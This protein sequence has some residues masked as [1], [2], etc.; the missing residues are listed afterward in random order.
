MAFYRQWQK[1]LSQSLV[2]LVVAVLG[3]ALLGLSGLWMVEQE[4][5]ARAGESLAL[6][7]T[8]VAGKLDAMLRERNGDIEI[9]AAAPQVRSSDA[10]QI[11]E[12]L[13]VVQRAYP[14]YTRLAVTDRTGRV[15]ASTDQAL[16]GQD[17]RD[18]SWF[19]AVWHVPRIYAESVKKT[20]QVMGQGHL[21]SVVISAPILGTHSTFHGAIMTEIDAA[22]WNRLVEDAVKPFAAQ[23]KSFGI[24]RYR[25]LDADGNVLLTQEGRDNP[26]INFRKVGLP[27]AVSVAAGLPG[28]VEEE[29]L[30][31]RVPVVTGYA[32]VQ[33]VHSL[34]TLQ[35]GVLVRAD[36][37]DILEN[38]Q[39][40]L[41]KIA[42]VGAA[43][44]ALMV[45]LI[46]WVKRDHQREQEKVARAQRLLRDRDSQL[47]AVVTHAV[48]GI[49][50][51]DQFGRILSFNPAAEKLFGYLAD[52]VLGCNASLL[53]PEPSVSEPDGSLLAFLRTGAAK[54]IGQGREVAGRRRD[55]SIFPMDV[56][57]S[58]MRIGEQRC[59][60]GIVRDITQRKQMVARL[61]EQEMFFRLLSDHLP[62]GVFE[63]D[64]R[65]ACVYGN[66]MW[67]S[68]F[69]LSEATGSGHFVKPESWLLW[70]H[71]DD[72]EKV[73]EEWE[74]ARTMFDRVAVECRLAEGGAEAR[75]VN[76]LLWSMTT[77][78][79]V[80]Y[81]G[82]LE[83][84]TD[85]K[86]TVAHTMT[87]LKHG[88]FELRTLTEAR[89]LAE[90]LA[91]AFPDPLRTKLGLTELLVNG[92]EHGNLEISY[93]EKSSLLKAGRLDAEIARRL[94]LQ[95]NLQKRVWV[96][97]DRKETEVDVEIVDAGKGF[98]WRRYL[99]LDGERSDDSHGRGIAMSRRISFDRLEFR[100]SGNHVIVSSQLPSSDPRADE[101]IG[102]E[103][104]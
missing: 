100:N 55:G 17:V 97:M 30:V 29:H 33:G 15:V 36:R 14:V 50:S 93:A 16:M 64:H 46:V 84:I 24:V 62:I 8:E 58:E 20:S 28:Y 92:V 94:A 79:G 9:L 23:A 19:Q 82:T 12:H 26:T 96:S 68:L 67:K 99:A 83:D 27:S 13:R 35:W 70:F 34:D 56:A 40:V 49:I 37:A 7:A 75:W 73:E 51:I 43:G 66:R 42:V 44:F 85:R 38:I 11:A 2:V 1:V 74:R 95:E 76:V 53:M 71:P 32:R 86:R 65:G 103:A 25:V 81:L 60:T 6:G 3:A 102:R 54:T 48:D 87:L 104:A 98:D 61:K 72:R 80:R 22:L 91:Y 47:G 63:I 101:V 90:L 39:G 89:N 77:E 10:A 18:A 88:R 59:F 31:R 21:Q 52:E 45:A 4:L 41:V 57:V 5:A 78:E 69:N